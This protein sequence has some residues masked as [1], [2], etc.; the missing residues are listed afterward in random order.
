[1][2]KAG[3]HKRMRRHRRGM[4]FL[5]LVF[6]LVGSGLLVSFIPLLLDPS[7]TIYANGVATTS[8][9]PKLS[10]VMTFLW[11]VACGL[12]FL[13]APARVIN[14]MFV[15]RESARYAIFPWLRS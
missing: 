6:A 4:R 3:V 7:A 2:K 10:G 14:R 12:F 1:M 5:G 15:W 11:F 8:I 9:G 13:F